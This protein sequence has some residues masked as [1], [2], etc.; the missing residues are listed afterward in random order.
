MLPGGWLEKSRK[1]LIESILLEELSSSTSYCLQ[2]QAMLLLI[3]MNI[4]EAAVHQD[5]QIISH[6]YMLCVLEHKSVCMGLLYANPGIQ[7][8]FPF[9]SM[10]QGRYNWL[11][12][13][14]CTV[15]HNAEPV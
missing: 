12:F 6:I 5:L 11:L 3:K 2:L 9:I 8:L 7:R 4:L 15:I 10:S 13:L 1:D 14:T